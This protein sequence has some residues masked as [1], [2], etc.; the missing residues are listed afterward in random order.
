[1][2]VETDLHVA[3][4]VP[5]GEFASDVPLVAVMRGQ[6]VGSLHRGSF[7]V[8]DVDGSPVVAAG[9]VRQYVFLRSAA[10]PFQA[11]PAVLSGA[12]ERFGLS[13]PEV[14]ILCASHSAEPRHMETVLSALSKAGLG[15]ESL[16]CGVH[17]PL[18]ERT[19]RDLVR[20]GIDPSPVCNNCSGAHTGMLLA[21]VAN[22]WPLDSY[23][24]PGHPLQVQ[25]R[26]ILAAFAGIPVTAVELATD[27][28]AV[29]TFRVPLVAAGTAFA[30]LITGRRVVPDYAAAARVLTNAMIGA[31]EMV[32]GEARFDTDVMEAAGAAV[33]SKGGAEAFQGIGLRESGLGIAM[34][35]T[36]GNSRAI[37]PAAMV[38]LD[39]LQP[40][41]EERTSY[42]D[43]YRTVEVQNPLGE[44]VGRLEPVFT[45]GSMA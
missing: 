1:M 5:G 45:V 17:P 29:P 4:D 44:T 9:D 20:R 34:K 28:C 39:A 13:V 41:P 25:T 8:S 36:D 32:G 35:I 33:V 31:P 42:L 19:A 40:L 18:H 26:D 15:E 7:V 10:K 37:G 27:N 38:L 43:D 22:G 16:R 30:R 24:D 3:I 21:C 14:A 6:Y 12:V 2:T 23:G 11:M